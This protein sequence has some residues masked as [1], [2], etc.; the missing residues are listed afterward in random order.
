MKAENTLWLN[1]S[2]NIPICFSKIAYLASLISL[3]VLLFSTANAQQITTDSLVFSTDTIR[4]NN[5][6]EEQ[7]VSYAEDSIDYDLINKKVHLYHNAKV[8][9]G[10]V[11]LTAAYIE[12]DSDE[13]TVYATWLKDSVGSVYGLPVF[14]EYGK[15][16][17]AD[18]ITYNFKSKK[19]LIKEVITKEGEGYVLGEKVKKQ[20]DD[21]IH[22]HSGR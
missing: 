21:V 1:S 18:A 15:S 20:D 7:V 3:S 19:G 9:Y 22:T 2:F 4:S 5:A 13:N 14:Q 17:T 6:L 12:L 16:F 8:T 11:V 10:G